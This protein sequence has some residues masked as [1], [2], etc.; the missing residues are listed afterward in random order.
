MQVAK[1]GQTGRTYF[2]PFKIVTG[3]KPDLPLGRQAKITV[4]VQRLRGAYVRPDSA[5]A[6]G[7]W[8]GIIETITKTQAPEQV[9]INKRFRVG[10]N[11]VQLFLCRWIHTCDR[12][13]RLTGRISFSPG[14]QASAN[15][16][17]K[18]CKTGQFT[19]FLCE[20]NGHPLAADHGIGIKGSVETHTDLFKRSEEHTSK[21]QKLM[22]I[23]NAV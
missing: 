8:I 9:K 6:V 13:H 4:Y 21:I 22:R 10:V 16:K 17:T 14:I 23:S 19:G 18:A 5:G 20:E 15:G 12:T 3:L 11:Q 1:N 2:G 7:A